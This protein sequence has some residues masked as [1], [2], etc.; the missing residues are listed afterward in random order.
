MEYKPIENCHMENVVFGKD[1]NLGTISSI[2]HAFT[3]IL[4]NYNISFSFH[5]SSKQITP[6]EKCGMCVVLCFFKAI[7]TPNANSIYNNKKKLL[8][9]T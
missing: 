9:H 4:F 3:Q 8:N 5:F 1:F 7:I 6:F 2:F